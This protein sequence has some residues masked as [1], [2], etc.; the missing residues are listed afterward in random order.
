[1]NIEF[2]ETKICAVLV[3]LMDFNLD[4]YRM[5]A[6]I[7]LNKII[8]FL[9][10]EATER[11]FIKHFTRLCSDSSFNV[12]RVCA[13]NFGEFCSVVGQ[14]VTEEVLLPHFKLLCEDS[15][16]GVR[17]ACADV[18]VPVSCV[19]SNE[20]RRNILASLFISLLSDPS[21]WVK[22]AAFQAL[23]PFISTFAD[24]SKTGLYYNNGT[25]IVVDDLKDH[26]SNDSGCSVDSNENTASPEADDC[27]ILSN[28]LMNLSLKDLKEQE[29]ARVALSASNGSHLHLHFD[30]E[31]AYNNFQY[32]RI[33]IPE[34]EIDIDFEK[35]KATNVHVRA[36]V[37]DDTQQKVYTSN[38]SVKVSH[39]D[40]SNEDWI[41]N[42]EIN[43]QSCFSSVSEQRENVHKAV[44]D[45]PLETFVNHDSDIQPLSLLPRDFTRIR[46]REE[47]RE[48]ISQS[49]TPEKCKNQLCSVNMGFHNKPAQK[50]ALKQNIIPAELLEHYLSMINPVNYQTIDPDLSH[51]CAYS[52]PAV[53][54]TLGR[55]YWP[56]LKETYQ[57]LASDMQWKVRWTLASS[58]H[59]MSLILGPEYTSRDL[60]PIFLS[61]MKDLDEVRFGVLQN[62]AAILELLNR[63]E[64]LGI[65]PKISDFLKMDNY[66]NWRFRLTLAQQVMAIASLY[67][68]YEIFEYLIPIG[69]TLIRDKVSEV[70]LSA[71]NVLSTLL[72]R[73]FCDTQNRNKLNEIET[74]LISDLK[75]SLAYSP[76]WV[77]RQAFILLCERLIIENS[78]PFK[79]FN[80]ELLGC[81]LRFSSDA[82]PNVRLVLARILST[83][84]HNI[85]WS[86]S[87]VRAVIKT[88]QGDKDL[89]VRRYLSSIILFDNNECTNVIQK[90]ENLSVEESIEQS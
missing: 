74:R 85:F 17:K 23:G 45:V 73:I 33:P 68:P 34:L 52:L 69:F 60:V 26:D 55:K 63:T 9:G 77:L 12:R 57:T 86:N 49:F 35:G 29:S 50:T 10:S 41:S 43:V 56:C 42:P 16:W 21:R 25:V 59:Q 64:Q 18:F 39:S 71:I 27:E 76:K 19:C 65:L 79:I 82:V 78:I 81:L 38:V 75:S 72:K 66:R 30:N 84:L 46:K 90:S 22:T 11:L 44:K 54:L 2:I 4:D 61:F 28:N 14:N 32:W 8:R 53:A 5:E 87:E 58:L 20:A 51:H 1:M 40:E 67:T 80:D 48:F 83:T 3:Q 62:L 89:D 6:L 31:S 24:P 47:K 88:L 70:R 7:T 36:K 37:H 13:S 15:V